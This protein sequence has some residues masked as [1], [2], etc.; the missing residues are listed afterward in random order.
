MEQQANYIR[1]VITDAFEY[2]YPALGKAS[3]AVCQVAEINGWGI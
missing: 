2:A 1:F 3:G